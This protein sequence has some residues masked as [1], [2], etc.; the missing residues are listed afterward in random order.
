MLLGADAQSMV[1][2]MEIC[3]EGILVARDGR[4]GYLRPSGGRGLACEWLPATKVRLD[5]AAPSRLAA[6]SD[7]RW[8]VTTSTDTIVIH[9]TDGQLPVASGRVAGWQELKALEWW[10][11]E[12]TRLEVSYTGSAGEVVNEDVT[13][14]LVVNRR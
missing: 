14:A 3:R 12:G 4:L 11:W 2:C 1:A 9:P 6:G 10:R 13:G 5:M 7:V 8:R